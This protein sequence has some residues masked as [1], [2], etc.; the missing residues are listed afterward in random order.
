MTDFMPTCPDPLT[1]Y[2]GFANPYAPSTTVTIA[3]TPET[4]RVIREVYRLDWE[5]DGITAT[6]TTNYT[7]TPSIGTLGDRVTISPAGVISIAWVWLPETAPIDD[8]SSIDPADILLPILEVDGMVNTAQ[9]P[10]D[11]PIFGPT[12][13]TSFAVENEGPE[14]GDYHQFIAYNGAHVEISVLR[15][16]PI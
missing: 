8:P 5:E 1:D 9:L 11:W 14:I 12:P 6:A 3:P 4:E 2:A 7:G 13:E 15:K 10:E 16:V